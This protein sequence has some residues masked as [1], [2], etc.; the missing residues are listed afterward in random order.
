MN[1]PETGVIFILNCLN[2]EGK[3]ET[4][5]A[6][7]R[8]PGKSFSSAA[9]DTTTALPTDEAEVEGPSV[10]KVF[11]MEDLDSMDPEQAKKHTLRFE[12][13]SDNI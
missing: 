2:L 13:P 11:P 9:D 8:A 5:D 12:R 4:V 10:L 1:D 7:P 6:S 3:I